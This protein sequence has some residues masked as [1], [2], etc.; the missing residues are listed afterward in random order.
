M[1]FKV[2][3]DNRTLETDANGAIQLKIAPSTSHPDQALSFSG[4][5]L[6][7][8]RGQSGTPGPNAT[9]N[10]P[11]NGVA[12]PNYSSTQGLRILGMNETV[13]RKCSYT[14]SDTFV[15]SNDGVQMVVMNSDN[16]AIAGGLAYF[17]LHPVNNGGE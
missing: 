17:I 14:G 16:S 1:V 9:T 8:T 11:G 4:G 10:T 5:K 6:I 13:S 12:P 3:V 15:K 7:A 2:N